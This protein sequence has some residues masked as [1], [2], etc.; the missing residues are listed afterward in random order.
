MQLQLSLTEALWFLP[1]V[2]PICGWVIYT[3]L[4]RM[5]ITNHANLA[6]VGVFVLVGLLALPLDIYGWRLV[7]LLVVLV[8]GFVFNIM[9][10]MGAGDSKFLAAA[11]PFIAPGD[12]VTVLFLL[13]IVTL[14]AIATHRWAKKTALRDMAP[15]WVSWTNAEKFPMGLALGSTLVLY[16]VMGLI[17]GA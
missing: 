1:F 9:G 15:D 4:S 5:K 13:S 14:T 8:L 6:L 7:Q 10:L 16:L 17:W 2:A 11:A 3:D 12:T